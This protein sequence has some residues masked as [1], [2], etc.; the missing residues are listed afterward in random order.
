MPEFVAYLVQLWTFYSLIALALSVYVDGLGYLVLHTLAVAGTG[1]YAYAIVSAGPGGS[2]PLGVAA[3]I[4]VG[5]FVGLI[6]AEGLRFHR[7][8]GLTLA[9]FGIGVGMFE[10]FRY[11]RITGGVYGVSRI[12][13]TVTVSGRLTLSVACLIAAGAVMAL[14][15]RSLGGAITRA[16]GLDEWAALSLGARL[17]AHQRISGCL[18]GMLAGAGGAWFAAMTRFIEARNF[19]PT[20]LLAPLAA[21]IISHGRTPAGVILAAAGVVLVSQGTRFLGSSPTIAGPLAEILLAVLVGAMLISRRLRPR[22]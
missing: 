4:A 20:D 21:V 14:W 7:S 17:S 1:A 6:C 19:R 22:A 10:I 3:A 16:L 18:S 9:S 12:P 15:S 11:A 5:A 8:D 2:V 13:G